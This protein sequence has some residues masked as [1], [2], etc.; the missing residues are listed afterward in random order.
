MAPPRWRTVTAF[1]AAVALV[2]AGG[3]CAGRLGPID[4]G[5]PKAPAERARR[6]EAEVREHPS[7]YP[8]WTALAAARL[9]LARRT[10][11]P[12]ELAAAR[13]AAERS[14]AI[15]PSLEG[16]KLR[17]S[18]EA[19]AH[20]FEE[21]ST[22]AARARTAAPDDAGA[23]ALEVE[24]LVAL[25]RFDDAQALLP[26]DGDPA[27]HFHTAAA[28]A[29]WRSAT[30]DTDGAEEAFAEAARLARA[31]EVPA[32]ETWAWVRAAGVRLDAGEPER[33]G[34]HLARAAAIAREDYELEIHRAG[35]DQA[36]GRTAEAE[37][38]YRRLLGRRDD[39]EI[40]RRLSV[41][42]RER[43]D[44]AAAERHVRAA[45]A[46]Y[47]RAVEAGEVYTLEGLARLR[48]EELPQP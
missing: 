26:A 20:R 44:A 42:A 23:I 27:E 21:A 6:Y 17:G 46:I 18:V 47:L 29:L 41:L 12:A 45:E 7:R 10:L 5:D 34:P 11:D 22:W 24:A 2:W 36:E 32:F 1:G 31:A 4:A 28:L 43:G 14:L 37:R 48:G 40:H 13:A 19:M 30:G 38:R 39:P 15:Q 16:Y 25:G 33:A 8:A 35:L 9:D 3:G